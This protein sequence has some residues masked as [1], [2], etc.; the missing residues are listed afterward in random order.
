MRKNIFL[1]VFVFFVFSLAMLCN[2]G[3]TLSQNMG[4]LFYSVAS[5]ENS[6]IHG[7]LD[8]SDRSVGGDGASE[9]GFESRINSNNGSYDTTLVFESETNSGIQTSSQNTLKYE[10]TS[11]ERPSHLRVSEVTKS[12]AVNA[13]GEDQMGYFNAGLGAEAFIYAG[14]HQTTSTNSIEGV[15]LTVNSGV[16][17]SVGVGGKGYY[18]GYVGPTDHG[19]QFDI[20][21]NPD[22]VAETDKDYVDFE[23][24]QRGEGATLYGIYAIVNP[25]TQ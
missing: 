2:V 23:L 24:K 5:G 7:N 20:G 17:G 15:N 22:N 14:Y 19:D 18:L 1:A 21:W 25:A 11:G 3:P 8:V 13:F 6:S 4:L 16:D 10:D 9:T 12:E